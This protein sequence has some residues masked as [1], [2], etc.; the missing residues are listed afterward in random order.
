MGVWRC[1]WAT[2][3]GVSE[4]LQLCELTPVVLRA[5]RDYLL[6][7][8][9]EWQSDDEY[10][11]REQS[12]LPVRQW[13]ERLCR[14]AIREYWTHKAFAAKDMTTEDRE[15]YL[16]RQTAGVKADMANALRERV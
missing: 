4:Q 2:R 11:G 5:R 8:T 12:R 7:M 13:I 14:M 3:I 15:R 1:S 10:P 16:A 9:A 6:K